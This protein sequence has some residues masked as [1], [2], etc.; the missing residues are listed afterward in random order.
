VLSRLRTVYTCVFAYELP[1]N[2][3]YDFLHAQGD[4]QLIFLP[5]CPKMCGKAIV[6]G[7]RRISKILNQKYANRA[8]SLTVFGTLN[9]TRVDGP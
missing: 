8:R 9:R 5:I 4:L 2:S 1:C 3:I 7:V 6:I